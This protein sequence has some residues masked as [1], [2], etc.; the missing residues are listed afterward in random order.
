M[1]EAEECVMLVC[2]TCVT[3]LSV[4]VV[5]NILLSLCV[6]SCFRGQSALGC[7]LR[8]SWSHKCGCA[9][10]LRAK[11]RTQMKRRKQLLGLKVAQIGAL[12]AL[13]TDGRHVEMCWM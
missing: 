12:R 10:I 6:K 4:S 3:I 11:S 1:V 5:K 8:D 9:V 7:C 2:V 13:A